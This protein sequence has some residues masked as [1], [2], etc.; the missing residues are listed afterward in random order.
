MT[1]LS[2]HSAGPFLISCGNDIFWTVDTD[3]DYAVEGTRNVRNASF[4]YIIPNDDG[5]NPYEFTIAYYGD[6]RKILR[7]GSSTLTPT[8]KQV[9][10][11]VARYLDTY[12][13]P[14][15]TNPGPLHLK[16]H[17]RESRSR[18]TLHSRIVRKCPPID[19]ATWVQGTDMYF[20]NCA[21]RRIKKDGYICMKLRQRHGQAEFLTGCVSSTSEHDDRTT[22]MLFRLL[23]PS[24]R[25]NQTANV[26]DTD[27]L[28]EELDAYED[29]RGGLG[30]K[31]KLRAVVPGAAV[32]LL[33]PSPPT[34]RRL[35][36][37]GGTAP[38]AI[39]LPELTTSDPTG[40]TSIIDTNL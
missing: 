2:A 21:R 10:E 15:G 6:N 22:F 30:M 39:A 34:K 4:F 13:R 29:K 31:D 17:L 27:Q 1:S 38:P 8:S 23:P 5:A 12:V 9:I 35:D 18:L 20:I 36:T 14:F 37:S 19:T 25:D 11:P 3:R 16:N 7:H 26:N 33:E 24:Y 40:A 28:D 32:R